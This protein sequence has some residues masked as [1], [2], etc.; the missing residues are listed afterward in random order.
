MSG[1]KRK[2]KLLKEVEAL[3]PDRQV[4]RWAYMAEFDVDYVAAFNELYRVMHSTRILPAKY[5][6]IIISVLLACRL[7]DRLP[8]HLDRALDAGASEG[9][10]L[11]G[12]QLAQMIFG[13]PSLL[14]GV[15]ALQ[16]VVLQRKARTTK[17]RSKS[18]R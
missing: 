7:A 10:L 11:E 15:D 12:L 2:Q 9:E 8:T 1:E 5:R 3:R 17:K 18:N 6:E 4:S 13:A 14:Y 16:G